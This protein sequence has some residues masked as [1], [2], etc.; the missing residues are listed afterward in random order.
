MRELLL[1]Y[2]ER[3]QALVAASPDPGSLAGLVPSLR[4]GALDRS[5]VAELQ[6]HLPFPLPDSFV[7]YL[8]GP[9]VESGLEWAEVSIPG[10]NDL[11][12][13]ASLMV[14]P[15]LWRLGL[16]QF[17]TGRCGD[18]VCFDYPSAVGEPAVVEIN[19]DR[20]SPEAWASPQLIRTFADRRWPSFTALLEEVCCD[21]P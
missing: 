6:S 14:R 4:P 18:D 7:G 19:H 16:L 21:E 5:A 9:L 1:A 13:F 8:Q 15:S 3:C 10:N 11:A 20:A 2:K 12:T 17:A